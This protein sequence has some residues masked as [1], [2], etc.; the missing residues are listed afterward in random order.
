MAHG[1]CVGGA[2][3]RKRAAEVKDAS[4]VSKKPKTEH[5]KRVPEA[6]ISA[7][8]ANWQEVKKDE[9]PELLKKFKS[10][11]RQHAAAYNAMLDPNFVK[12]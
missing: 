8:K 1:G 7:E 4:V 12:T 3:S 9:E 10:I 6:S 11:L 5:V 2:L